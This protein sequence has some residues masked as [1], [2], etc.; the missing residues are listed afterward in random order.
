MKII[1]WKLRFLLSPLVS[2]EIF[3]LDIKYV[4][5]MSHLLKNLCCAVIVYMFTIYSWLRTFANLRKTKQNKP[6]NYPLSKKD[7]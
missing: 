7:S 5:W 1:S 3:S 4:P 6:H 2:Y